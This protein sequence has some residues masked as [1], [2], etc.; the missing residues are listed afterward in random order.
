MML[1][2]ERR[3]ERNW[4][5]CAGSLLLYML[6]ALLVTW[7]LVL[8]MSTGIYAQ[9]SDLIGTLWGI[10][11]LRHAAQTG[12][13]PGHTDLVDF[14]YG[15]SADYNFGPYVK[16]TPDGWLNT[17]PVWWLSNLSNENVAIN[18]RVLMSLIMSALLMHMVVYWIVR[19]RLA[20]F[21]GGLV[22]MISPF[23]LAVTQH[24]FGMA[25]IECLAL[26]LLALLW[27]H[28][29]PGL[30]RS[31]GLGAAGAV[32]FL[33]EPYYGAY[34][35]I[36][37]VMY[38]CVRCASDLIHRDSRWLRNSGIAA[39]ALLLSLVGGSLA[40]VPLIE[41]GQDVPSFFFRSYT[42]VVE[43]SAQPWAY[44][45]PTS[46]HP[47]LAGPAKSLLQNGTRTAFPHLQ[48]LFLGYSV[49][50]LG[51]MGAFSMLKRGTSSSRNLGVFLIATLFTGVALSMPPTLSVLGASLPMPQTVLRQL[52]P[53][54]RT[55][56]RFGGLPITALAVLSGVGLS[57]L[58]SKSRKRGVRLAVTAVFALAICFEYADMPPV[59]VQN[60][61]QYEAVYY[62]LRD[63]ADVRVVAEYPLSVQPE[64]SEAGT[65]TWDTYEAFLNQRLHGKAL[66][67]GAPY[68]SHSYLMK[69]GLEDLTDPTV[70]ARLHWFG[71]DE[72]ILH[73]AA[74]TVVAAQGLELVY[75]GEDAD[76]YRI[77][78]SVAYFDAQRFK[79]IPRAN[80]SPRDRVDGGVNLALGEGLLVYGPYVSLPGGIYSVEFDLTYLPDA[81]ELQQPSELRL[82]V[83]SSWG[84]VELATVD[85]EIPDIRGGSTKRRFDL[86]FSTEDAVVVEFRVYGLAGGRGTLDFNGVEV[87]KIG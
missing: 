66:F 50:L 53:W 73:N 29:H 43:Y 12:E 15:R 41:L 20:A 3:G 27:F 62:W 48:S 14:P 69:V 60:T 51:S 45:L 23:R 4:K 26:F 2:R 16:L 32:C 28:D 36:M 18:L 19:D 70:P 61:G 46:T 40:F 85:V 42:Q 13:N 67:N 49:I 39:L 5:G 44:L 35:A 74:A 78:S 38:V 52:V 68:L 22:F 72:V 25:F 84:T 10:W 56:A 82:A 83:T 34:A 9:R 63:Q 75:R 58:L 87:E 11:C 6:V 33:I 79:S 71:V 64:S 24:Y 65:T 80:A 76:V 55:Y 21:V 7:P 86:V 31:I 77:D 81:L 8:T 1:E 54:V 47:I 59:N 37:L 57:W 30:F 17:Y